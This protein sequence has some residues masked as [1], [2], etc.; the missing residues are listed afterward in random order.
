MSIFQNA[1]NHARGP[2]EAKRSACVLQPGETIHDFA[3]AAAVELGETAQIEHHAW[4]IFADDF[5]EGQLELLALHTHLQRSAQLENDDAWLQ[6]FFC[7]A[8]VGLPSDGKIV[9]GMVA[10]SQSQSG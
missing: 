7:N 9:K 5:I 6:L 1:V 4:A 3:Q 10:S 8:H 2:G